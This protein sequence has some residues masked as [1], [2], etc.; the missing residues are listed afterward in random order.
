[1]KNLKQRT[2]IYEKF[3]HLK[4]RITDE[5]AVILIN[6]RIVDVGRLVKGRGKE[7]RMA[8]CSHEQLKFFLFRQGKKDS[9]EYYGAIKD[10]VLFVYGLHQLTY[11]G[12]AINIR[13]KYK[14]TDGRITQEMTKD[15]CFTGYHRSGD[16][17]ELTAA[18][19]IPAKLK[20]LKEEE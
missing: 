8:F 3:S 1:M 15:N 5:K 4:V 6:G 9:L 12:S 2:K 17:R 19:K 7:F 14:N 16:Q 11:K 10:S 20:N 13:T 18:I